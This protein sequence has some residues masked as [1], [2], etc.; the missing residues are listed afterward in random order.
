M[1]NGISRLYNGEPIEI[2]IKRDFGFLGAD[3]YRRDR[4][5]TKE[6]ELANVVELMEE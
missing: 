1:R 5:I 6:K 2:R 3:L 4:I